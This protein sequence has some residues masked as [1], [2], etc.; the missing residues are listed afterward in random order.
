MILDAFHTHANTHT[1]THAPVEVGVSDE[2][3]HLADGEAGAAVA[4]DRR[5][6]AVEVARAGP[7]RLVGVGDVAGNALDLVEAAYV[8]SLGLGD[9]RLATR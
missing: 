4:A 9:C 8:R 3:G 2:L 6:V 1:H 7:T 5:R